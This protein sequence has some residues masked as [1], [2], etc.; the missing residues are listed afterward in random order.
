MKKNADTKIIYEVIIADSK[1]RF[2]NKIIETHTIHGNNLNLLFQL[3]AK[4]FS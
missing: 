3:D 4:F 1:C 2:V